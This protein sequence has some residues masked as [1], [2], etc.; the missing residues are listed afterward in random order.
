MSVFNSDFRMVYDY[1]FEQLYRETG[2]PIYCWFIIWNNIENSKKLPEFV[3][4]YL[5]KTASNILSSDE[6]CKD[7][8]IYSFVFKQLG[9][10]NRKQLKELDEW[11][12]RA[13]LRAKVVSYMQ[14]H[15]V[16]QNK[17]LDELGI[18]ALESQYTH[19]IRIKA[20]EEKKRA[21]RRDMYR[22]TDKKILEALPVE[23]L[24][25]VKS[26]VLLD[27]QPYG[28]LYELC[29]DCPERFGDCSTTLRERYHK[30][31]EA[32]LRPKF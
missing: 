4:E 25:A 15:G 13:R 32:I 18:T 19:L 22:N 23:L 1:D 29:S 6:D 12:S 2:N 28:R 31:F 8:N 14:E 3:L 30:S 26:D 24:C 27:E 9:F 10:K 21:K 20:D 5:N 16:S 11:S 17:A 7:K